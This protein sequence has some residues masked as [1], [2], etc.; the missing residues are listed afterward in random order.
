MDTK[1]D[2]INENDSIE[3]LEHLEPGEFCIVNIPIFNNEIERNL[4]S[5]TNVFRA[6]EKQ[7]VNH[8]CKTVTLSPQHPIREAIKMVSI[9]YI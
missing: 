6:N 7:I 1:L 4:E 2:V 3:Y 8:T 9:S 5:I